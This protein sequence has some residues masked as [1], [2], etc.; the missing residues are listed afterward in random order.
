MELLYFEESK[1]NTLVLGARAN[2]LGLHSFHTICM[3]LDIPQ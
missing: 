3:T 1:E 2:G